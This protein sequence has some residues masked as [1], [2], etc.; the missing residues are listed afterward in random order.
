MDNTRPAPASL[1]AVVAELELHASASGWD[2]PPTLYAL[3][4][5]AEL[6]AA[7]PQL[8]LAPESGGLTPVEQEGLG[9]G[10]LD[11][12]L[13]RIAWPPA[14]VGCAIVHEVLVLPP[15]AED[16]RPTGADDLS[17]AQ[18]HAE[19]REVRMTVAVL[20]DGARAAALRVRPA[21]G[22]PE[23]DPAF[24]EDLAPN[25]AKALLGTFS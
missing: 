9:D 7:E 24:G 21:P 8:G 13:A 15:A 17:W 18:G 10:P 5:T 6:A 3:V 14:V 1:K 22:E 2:R 20:Q 25:L 12:A 23:T 4:D 11:E 16:A 19:R